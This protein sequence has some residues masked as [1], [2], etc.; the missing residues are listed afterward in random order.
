MIAAL[1]FTLTALSPAPM[2]GVSNDGEG[3]V[4]APSGKPFTLLGRGLADGG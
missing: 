3:F 2:D 4:L 1:L